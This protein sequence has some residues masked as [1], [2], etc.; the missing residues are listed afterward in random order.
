MNRKDLLETLA[1]YLDPL[2]TEHGFKWKKSKQIF[3]KKTPE[4]FWQMG[5]YTYSEDN[6][7]YLEPGFDIR[8]NRVEEVFVKYK[9]QNPATAKDST[10]LSATIYS[11][12]K[13]DRFSYQVCTFSDIELTAKQ[14][15]VFM[16]D[17]GFP[18]FFFFYN[19]K[20]MEQLYNRNP[21]NY[22]VK[23]YLIQKRAFTSVILAKMLN[24]GDYSDIVEYWEKRIS[25][26][27][28]TWGTDVILPLFL[29]MKKD[30]EGENYLV[31]D[32]I[33]YGDDALIAL[34]S[35]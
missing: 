6:C 22:I 10:T 25:A 12:A 15:I 35:K 31:D 24:K 14:V 8:N 16:K 27:E 20:Q 28:S 3:E 17:K 29:A 23:N 33:R 32:G 34:R 7:M 26:M 13:R 11:I 4:G 2:F 21:D 18:F 9:L 5:F 30:L 19:I 1:L